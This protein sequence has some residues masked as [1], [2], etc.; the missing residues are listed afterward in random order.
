[1]MNSKI[2]LDLLLRKHQ[3]GAKQITL[4]VPERIHSRVVSRGKKKLSKLE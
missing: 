2:N 3:K 1:M 4:G